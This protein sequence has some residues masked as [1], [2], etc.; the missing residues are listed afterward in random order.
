MGPV[1]IHAVTGTADAVAFDTALNHVASSLK[2]LGD[3]DPVQVRRA[4]AIGVLADPQHALDLHAHRRARRRRNHP[5]TTAHPHCHHGWSHDP[6]AP[7]HR[8]DRNVH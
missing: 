7:A 3:T 2:A 1:E 5:G 6:C 4:K 8:R